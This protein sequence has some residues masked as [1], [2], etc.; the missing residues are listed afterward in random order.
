MTIQRTKEQ[1]FAV[2]RQARELMKTLAPSNDISDST[3]DGYLRE[4]KRLLAK[5]AEDADAIWAAAC[6]T[7]SKRTYYR[8]LAS[9]KFG[10][11]TRMQELLRA[12][13]AAQRAGEIETW[14]NA[15]AN[16]DAFLQTAEGVTEKIDSL[17]GRCPLES[18]APKHSK[19]KDMQGLP[20]DWR[21]RMAQAFQGSK[22]RLDFLV[23]AVT[24]CRPH[25]LATGVEVRATATHILLK[26]RGAKVKK[27]QGQPWREMEYPIDEETH[28]LVRALHGEI[29]PEYDNKLIEIQTES[30][31]NFTSSIRRVG[32]LL[33]PR[34]ASEITPYCLRH[35]LA[36]DFK[37]SLKDLDHVSAAL[38]QSASAT[39]SMYGQ[40]QMS[41][42]SGLEP[43]SVKADR[44]IRQT[45]T[46]DADLRLLRESRPRRSA[47]KPM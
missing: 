29:W 8:R 26:I 31:V 7:E 46:A 38:G 27:T 28:P 43:G 13:D 14:Q 30:K 39:R 37:C 36:S 12:Q 5:G 45:H 10:I 32:R 23:A 24:G 2:I 41:R 9:L 34:R 20:P 22:Y 33:W 35:Q 47:K 21:E 44:P 1:A 42:G 4:F 6:D 40:R 15:V 11:P 17:D 18:P 25:E 19:R 3:R 16:L